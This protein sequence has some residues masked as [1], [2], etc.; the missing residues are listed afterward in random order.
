M[1]YRKMNQEKITVSEKGMII[2][3]QPIY[4]DYCTFDKEATILRADVLKALLIGEYSRV[5]KYKIETEEEYRFYLIKDGYF[6][7]LSRIWNLFYKKRR[8][9]NIKR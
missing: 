4:K 6:K 8:I 3:I 9:S 2:K 5:E 7:I 1:E